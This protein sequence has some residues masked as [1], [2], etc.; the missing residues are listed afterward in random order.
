[1]HSSLLS[2]FIFFL[3]FFLH[4][5][6]VKSPLGPHNP[7][8]SYPLKINNQWENART[9]T[10]FNIGPDLLVP[11]SALNITTTHVIK[12]TG[13]ATLRDSIET[14]VLKETFTRA[15]WTDHSESFYSIEEDGLYFHAYNGPGFVIPQISK[16]SQIRFKGFYFNSIPEITFYIT[17]AIIVNRMVVDSLIHEIPPLISLIYPPEIAAQWTYR[18]DGNPWRIDKNI[19]GLE[20]VEVPAG[21]YL[22]Y[23]IQWLYDFNLDSKWDEDI[24]F[25]D[26]I[27]EVGLLKRSITF[28][29]IPVPGDPG[30]PPSRVLGAKDESVL[31][32]FSL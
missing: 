7:E 8:F 16:K 24:V 14:F 31:T 2:F 28:L 5:G 21:N 29:N 26:F 19:I 23:K 17:N 11:D 30:I 13:K 10:Q 25:Y 9:F 1:M 6:Q 15:N 20:E 3:L 4:C 27:C 12:I 18:T 32:S 22:C